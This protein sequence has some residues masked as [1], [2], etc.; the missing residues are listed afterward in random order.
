MIIFFQ[1]VFINSLQKIIH[2]H[3]WTKRREERR[4]KRREKR[5]RIPIRKTGI[6]SMNLIKK[7]KKKKE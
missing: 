3:S 2:V 7:E 1:H 5:R 4:E 6:F